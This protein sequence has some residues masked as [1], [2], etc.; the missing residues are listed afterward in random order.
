ME[1][2]AATIPAIITIPFDYGS[3]IL[4]LRRK[5][6]FLGGPQEMFHF[7]QGHTDMYPVSTIELKECAG[8]AEQKAKTDPDKR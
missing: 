2:T 1:L 6:F 3:S 4:L 5:R 7:F 8:R